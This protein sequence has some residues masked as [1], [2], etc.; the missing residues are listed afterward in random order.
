MNYGDRLRGNISISAKPSD[1]FMKRHHVR[2][3]HVSRCFHCQ[4]GWNTP[5]ERTRPVLFGDGQGLAVGGAVARV[6]RNHFCVV[7]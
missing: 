1:G 7:L 3:L 6:G 2:R 5:T 4:L